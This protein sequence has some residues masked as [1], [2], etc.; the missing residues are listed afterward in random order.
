VVIGGSYLPAAEAAARGVPPADRSAA[1]L[2]EYWPDTGRWTVIARLR[3]QLSAIHPVRGD[4]DGFIAVDGGERRHFERSAEG[5]W[6]ESGAAIEQ[7]QAGTGAAGRPGGWRLRIAEGLNLPPDL[8]AD[9]PTGQRVRLTHLNPQYG[10]SWGTMRPYGW[11]DARG[12]PWAGGL[13]VPAGFV[14]GRAHPLVIQTYGFSPDRFYLDGANAYD[15]FTSG[16]PGRAF[17][18]EGILVLA[19]P[20]RAGRDW[21]ESHADR[22]PAFADG[23]RGAIAALV[24]DG[25]VDPARVGIMGWSAT[26]ERVLN[27]LAFSDV[28][29]RSASI[30]DGDANTVFSMAVTYAASDSIQARK[31]E[32]NQ[33]TPFG[34]SLDRWVRN[35]PALHTDCI[36]AALRIESYGPWVLNNWDV[37]ALMRRQYKPVEMVLIPEGSHGLLTPSD[38]MISLQGNVDWHRFWLMPN[39]R[40]EDRPSSEDTP[41]EVEQH[42]RWGEML[43]LK[44]AD[45]LRSGCSGRGAAR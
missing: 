34:A 32:T 8:V 13:M 19:L 31:E 1:H 23:V 5:P 21:P 9:G 28:P 35:D 30:L 22:L 4:R 40:N 17:L 36:L 18:R 44:Q 42:A 39:R 43:E 26:G 24:A 38:R 29:I 33:G 15:G 37:Y 16:F 6:R 25:L 14:A 11:N 12:R 7:P 2:I 10:P 20:V 3:G 41:A 27:L 45:E